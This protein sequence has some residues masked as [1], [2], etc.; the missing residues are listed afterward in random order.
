MGSVTLMFLKVAWGWS[1]WHSLWEVLPQVGV[2]QLPSQATATLRIAEF[3]EQLYLAHFDSFIRNFIGLLFPCQA[4]AQEC[5][6][7]TDDSWIGR[8]VNWMKS[9][10]QD[11][12]PKVNGKSDFRRKAE[13]WG[14]AY[15]KGEGL[16]PARRAEWTFW[17][18]KYRICFLEERPMS[19]A[20]L[21]NFNNI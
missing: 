5:Q 14:Q 6:L 8:K 16:A 12:W 3:G 18:L 7:S 11:L 2:S 21:A 15:V 10:S 20:H 19:L 13:C 9:E 17:R 4:C 1:L